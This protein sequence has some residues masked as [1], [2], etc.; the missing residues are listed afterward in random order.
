V[1]VPVLPR[2]NECRESKG[3]LKEAGQQPAMA[4]RHG[5]AMSVASF[6]LE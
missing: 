6:R 1:V 4:Q 5:Q 2:S 3:D